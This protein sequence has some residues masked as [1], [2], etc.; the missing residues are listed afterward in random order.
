MPALCVAV[1]RRCPAGELLGWAGV[2]FAEGEARPPRES[3]A[4]LEGAQTVSAATLHAL[5]DHLPGM[6]WTTD[7]DLRCT[8][9]LG[10][11]LRD[12]ACDPT[13]SSV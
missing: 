4:D 11:G 8:S 13:R 10:A 3:V 9:S 2:L 1:P 6:I 7:R 12:L 5:L